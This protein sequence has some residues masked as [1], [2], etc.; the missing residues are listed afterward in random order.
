[1][2]AGWE[3]LSRWFGLSRASFAVLPRVLMQ[4]MPDEWQGRM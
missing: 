2:S 4:Q 1:M 3:A